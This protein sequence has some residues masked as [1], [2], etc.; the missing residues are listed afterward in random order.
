MHQKNREYEFFQTV[1]GAV[2][3]SGTDGTHPAIME[4]DGSDDGIIHLKCQDGYSYPNRHAF[5]RLGP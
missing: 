3:Y 1:Q 5:Q 4:A 2:N